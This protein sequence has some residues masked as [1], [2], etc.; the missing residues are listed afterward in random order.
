M[1]T[2]TAAGSKASR[3]AH[4]EFEKGIAPY[5]NDLFR[6]CR[7]LTSNPWDAED[8][9][10]ETLLKVYGRLADKH[11]G[12][13]NPKAFLFKTAANQWIDWCRR[14]KL[15]LESPD[16]S[17]QPFS[18]GVLF[19][20]RNALTLTLQYL[21]PKERLALVLKDIFDFTL[22]EIAEVSQSTANA[23]KAAL[24]RAR[25]KMEFITYK[26]IEESRHFACANRDLIEKAVTAFNARD[27]NALS[28]LF[29]AS[30]TA[31]APGCFLES[32]LDEIKKGSLF[33]TVNT[34]IGSP[35]PPEIKAECIEIA[36]E[37]LFVLWNGD[38]LDDIW[39]IKTEDGSLAGFD[40]YCCPHVLEEIAEI[41]GVKFNFHGYY[42]EHGAAAR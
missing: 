10:Q 18:M 12:F 27:L 22:D 21:P 20:V 37:P 30:A 11:S 26:S 3:K 14:A 42:C 36:G 8:L 6:F 23:V 2:L 33:Y 7:S 31:N 5:R 4:I 13:D 1:A 15:P 34:S 24:H 17:L 38:K 25:S 32:N 19:E 29:L 41:L 35:Q 40:C 16:L 28:S 9:V 39:R